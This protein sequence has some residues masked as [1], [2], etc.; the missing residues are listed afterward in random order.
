VI[1]AYCPCH[2]G[3]AYFKQAVETVAPFADR[4]IILYTAQPSFGFQ[5]NSAC[6]DTEAVVRACC[7]GVGPKLEWHCGNWPTEGAHRDTIFRLA[8]DAELILPFD[9]DEVWD[10]DALAACIDHARGSTARTFRIQGW[11]HFWRSFDWCCRD[12]WAPVRIIKPGG[13][14]SAELQGRVYHFGYAQPEATI[15]YKMSIHGHKNEL[16]LRW[17]EDIFMRWPERNTDLH[18]TTLNWWNAEPFDKRTLPKVLHDHPFY[19]LDV[20]R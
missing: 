14:D 1:V 18:P 7:D 11:F 8:P 10:A 15:R 5:A 2:Y 16:R 17:F 3:S 6:P 20:I 12:V 4:V 19:S 13:V 9:S